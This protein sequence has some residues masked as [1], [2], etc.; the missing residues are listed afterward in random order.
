MIVFAD[1]RM[2]KKSASFW[3]GQSFGRSV[4]CPVQYVRIVPL[5]PVCKIRCAMRV[6]GMRWGAETDSQAGD[7]RTKKANQDE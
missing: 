4:N 6:Q 5:R 7:G 3:L 1:D 2:S